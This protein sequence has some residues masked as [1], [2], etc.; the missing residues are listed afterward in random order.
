[1]D[2]KISLLAINCPAFGP[3]GRIPK[4]HTGFGEDVSPAFSIGGL[5]PDIASLAIIM[6]DLDIPVLGTLNHWLCWNIPAADRI[7]ES[8]PHG[9]TL[10]DGTKQGIGYGKHRYRGPKQPP[11][12][13]KEHR[14][15]IAVYGLDCLLTLSSDAKK[16]DLVK[17]MSGHVLAQGEIIGRYKP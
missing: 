3:D 15:R 4:Q 9:A 13:K 14:Y 16:A 7:A 6:D 10:P 12:I 1:M 2:N 11:F 17:A 5:K 8:M